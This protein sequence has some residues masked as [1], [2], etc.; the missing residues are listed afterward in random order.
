[1]T[2]TEIVEALR[3]LRA[4]RF[5]EF[6]A[7][8]I[9]STKRFR[10]IETNVTEHGWQFDILAEEDSG[11]ISHEPTLWY[12]DVKAKRGR[13]SQEDISSIGSLFHI[14]RQ[15]NPHA[16]LV[17]ASLTPPSA[18]AK[19]YAKQIGAEIWDASHLIEI[20]A[21]D[22][23]QAYLGDSAGRGATGSHV[24][25]KADAYRSALLSVPVGEE[26]W[27]AYQTLVR[28][29]LEFLYC[30]PLDQPESESADA[31]K[32]NRRD[33]ILGNGAPDGFWAAV[34]S[35]YDAH[36]VVA[37]AKNYAE[38]VGKR[39]ILEVAHYLKSYG[40]GLFGMVLSRRGASAAGQHAIREQW[41]ASRKMII[42]LSDEDVLTMLQLKIETGAPE[43]FLRERIRRF[44]LSL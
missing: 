43:E 42:A 44:R 5:E 2:H 34:R 21:A 22:V 18:P 40:C 15:Q 8:V 26:S 17:I 33:I 10:R 16:R 25:A 35:I 4:L 13:L 38:P 29:V 30:P 28:D 11:G 39:P 7:D 1:M 31:D 12:F 24:R 36:Y 3:G 14:T 41:I 37:D 20:A 9:R 32:R 27:V 19:A 6:V 23:L